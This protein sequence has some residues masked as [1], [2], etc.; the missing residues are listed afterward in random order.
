MKAS[1]ELE[2]ASRL[3]FERMLDKLSKRTTEAAYK[4]LVKFLFQIKLL[5]QNKLKADRHIVTSRLRNSIY[6]KTH[7]QKHANVSGNSE[8]Y[9][10]DDGNQYLNDLSAISISEN[11]GAVGTNVEYA[12][13]IETQYDSFLYWAAEN[14]DVD[15]MAR[16]ISQ[17]LLGFRQ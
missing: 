9:G 11:E 14:A 17:E 3:N 13:K 1:I 7:E 16:E 10:D 5:A 8:L 15:R 6:V 2:K 12:E 4:G